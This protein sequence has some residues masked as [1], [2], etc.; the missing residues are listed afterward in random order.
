[1]KYMVRY[2]LVIITIPVILSCYRETDISD[3]PYIEFR[4]LE[5]VPGS[6]F[7][8]LVLSF[9]FEDGDGN[10]GL[11]SRETFPPF[12]PFDYV[13]DDDDSLVTLRSNSTPPFRLVTPGTLDEK[14]LSDTDIRTPYNCEDYAILDIG[15]GATDTFFI[16]KN[17][18]H[19]NLHLNF[20]RKVN[21]VYQEIDLESVFGTTS[22]G[23]TY[24]GR[25][26]VFDEES[27]E[28]QRPVRGTITYP[29]TSSG[30][31]FIFGNDEFKIEFYV[32]DFDLNLSNVASTPDLTLLGITR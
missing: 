13:V 28:N 16:K 26:P 21:G 29:I 7:D 4:S 6:S 18:F 1:M 30:F 22:C 2:F 25:I 12:H 10:V 17:E 23:I 5:F 9:Y 24:D 20:F 11:F 14:F 15:T 27:V 32:Y 8:S 19:Y 3:I 31:P